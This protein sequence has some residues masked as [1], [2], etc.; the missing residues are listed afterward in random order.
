MYLEV[1]IGIT[2]ADDP[3]SGED[4]GLLSSSREGFDRDAGGGFGT[5]ELVRAV[6]RSPRPRDIERNKQRRMIRG[7]RGEIFDDED[8]ASGGFRVYIPCTHSHRK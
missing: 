8:N 4:L 7:G 1:G 6:V 2:S 3:M 5:D